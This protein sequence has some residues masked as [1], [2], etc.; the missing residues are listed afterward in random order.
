MCEN[1]IQSLGS[2]QL[3]QSDA[4]YAARACVWYFWREAL[5]SGNTCPHA[6]RVTIPFDFGGARQ[7]PHHQG[8]CKHHSEH[9]CEAN[10]GRSILRPYLNKL[11]GVWQGR[12]LR[13]GKEVS[14]V[15]KLSALQT[16]LRHQILNG[17]VPTASHINVVNL[18]VILLIHTHNQH[19]L[20]ELKSSVNYVLKTWFDVLV[21]TLLILLVLG[22]RAGGCST[23]KASKI[24][25]WK[26]RTG[27]K[28]PWLVCGDEH[29]IWHSLK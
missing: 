13:S 9:V 15:K 11:H 26:Q 24:T 7:L 4:Y 10:I 25:G 20:W 3:W 2:S 29:R 18:F 8:D 5:G 23:R 16:P 1:V 28:P 12:Q 21:H 14:S 6:E 17:P 22:Y 27:D 19:N